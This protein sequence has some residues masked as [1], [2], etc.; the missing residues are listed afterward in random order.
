ML[1]SRCTIKKIKIKQSELQFHL[2][3][4]LD[5]M[6]SALECGLTSILQFDFCPITCWRL[7][8]DL[9][10]LWWQ[11]LV[12]CDARSSRCAVVCMRAHETVPLHNSTSPILT[13][14]L[15]QIS[16]AFWKLWS[17]KLLCLV[18]FYL[19]IHLIVVMLIM[20]QNKLPTPWMFSPHHSSLHGILMYFWIFCFAFHMANK[21]ITG[22]G[23]EQLHWE[24]CWWHC[25]GEKECA[26]RCGLV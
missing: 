9:G 17:A 25:T 2:D 18:C 21:E 24:P 8:E 23:R 6:N 14:W 3:M 7:P 11:L 26:K 16:L 15:Y 10:E 4:L 13:R 5:S 19:G 12:L 20:K 1:R 22:T